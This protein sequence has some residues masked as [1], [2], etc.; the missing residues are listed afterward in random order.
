MSELEV[1]E[2]VGIEATRRTVATIGS[3]K[4][5]TQE[6]PIVFD[7]EV[8]RSIVGTVFSVANGSSFWRKSSY[9][10][11]KEGQQV[12]PLDKALAMQA[13]HK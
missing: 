6:C 7:P 1:A 5:E 11:G 13:V 9:L 8:A 10:V 3:K 4:V 12:M 2:A